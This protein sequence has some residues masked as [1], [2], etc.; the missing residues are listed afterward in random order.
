MLKKDFSLIEHSERIDSQYSGFKKAC[1]KAMNSKGDAATSHVDWSENVWIRQAQEEKIAY[2]FEDQISLHA[3]RFYELDGEGS[4]LSICDD[5]FHGAAAATA[6]I[7]PLLDELVKNNCK[8]IIIVCDSPLSQYRNKTIFWFM[9]QF[10][11]SHFITF[12]CIYL[13]S[14]HGKGATIWD[15]SKCIQDF[16][17]LVFQFTMLKIYWAW[18]WAIWFNLL[19]WCNTQQT[20][21][22]RS[23]YSYHQI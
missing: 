6:S 11:T 23:W 18:T 9:K 10:S 2:Y 16:V 4:L 21:S 17:I 14:G 22:T 19:F 8:K 12:K 15:W 1:I 5:T 20:K 3:M 7:K 13:E